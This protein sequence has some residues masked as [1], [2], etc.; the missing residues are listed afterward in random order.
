MATF[1]ANTLSPRL[2]IIFR[3]GTNE[4]NSLFHDI[5]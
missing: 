4:N 3:I 5:G 1:F 2:F